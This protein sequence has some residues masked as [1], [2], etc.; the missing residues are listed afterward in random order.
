MATQ[1]LAKYFLPLNC[2]KVTSVAV[3]VRTG[4]ICFIKG[5]KIS[6]K[7]CLP[8]VHVLK[9]EAERWAL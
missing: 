9:G 8:R 3:L 1:Q 6:A 5:P 4:Q 2:F 7:V